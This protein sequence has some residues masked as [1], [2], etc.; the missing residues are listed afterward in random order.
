MIMG[1]YP[2]KTSVYNNIVEKTE[3]DYLKLVDKYEELIKKAERDLW[4]MPEGVSYRRM[5]V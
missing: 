1:A 5:R 3:M 4:E 2:N